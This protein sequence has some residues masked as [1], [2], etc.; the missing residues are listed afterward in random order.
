MNIDNMFNL[1]NAQK[2]LNKHKENYRWKSP[3]VNRVFDGIL[4]FVGNTPIV[5]L[6]NIPK[7][8]GLSCEIYVKCEFMNPGGSVKDR[9][10]LAM[11]KDA[12][13]FISDGTHFVE[14][15]SGNTGIGVAMN[16]ALLKKKCTIVMGEKNST[17]KVDTI[18]LFGANV[19]QTNKSST[20][21]ARQIKDSDPDT[22]LMLDQFENHCNPK[23]HYD[24][25][26]L[27][28]LNTLGEVDMLVAGAGT[29][30]TIT[31]VG[32][33][34]KERF[35]KCV[36]IA[37][38]PDGSTMFNEHAK[39]HPFLVEG[40]GGSTVPI[41]LD[42]S[43]ADDYE[44]VTDE[45][46]F[47]MARELI[48]KEGILCGG[49]SGTALAA[50]IKAARRRNMGPGKRIVVIMPD[51]IRNYMSKFVID[52]WMEAH[53]F[54]DP[55]ERKW[56]WWNQPMTNIIPQKCP[57]VDDKTTVIEA[58]HEMQR[59]NQ[60]IAIVVDEKG[61]F[62]GAITKN[63]IRH[64]TTNSTKPDFNFNDPVSDHLAKD[65]YTLAKNGKKGMPKI[66][67]L[68]RILDITPFVVIGVE[69]HEIDNDY[70]LPD[71]VVT[72]DNVFDYIFNHL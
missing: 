33:R 58:I 48:K 55:P 28:I 32:Y 66:G 47:L 65:C 42:K 27:E 53:L 21:I 67:R 11:A 29:G 10:A 26:G 60:D 49:S 3:Y 70:F 35:P 50:A 6:N 45:E 56:K 12:E 14:A 69:I 37:A 13:P 59:H 46:S 8:H 44:V 5:K 22:F 24:T 72:G 52:Q 54:M 16:A 38:E 15:T 20:E 19:I 64:D 4:D 18:R 71:G 61:W 41:V 40:I 9:I 1:T 34:I 7:D 43:I 2:L 31:G 17:Q 62:V 25:T 57:I 39:K 30:G 63:S 36:I 23:V 51:G 68:S